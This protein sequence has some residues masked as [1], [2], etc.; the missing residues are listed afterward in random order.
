[1]ISGTG[2]ALGE[3]VAGI[4]SLGISSTGSPIE[5]FTGAV[6]GAAGLSARGGVIA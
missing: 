6:A 4:S 5:G 3:V 2:S 1:M